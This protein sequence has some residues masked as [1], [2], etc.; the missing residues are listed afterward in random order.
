LEKRSGIWPWC[1]SWKLTAAV[2]R[3]CGLTPE[4]SGNAKLRNGM[5]LAIL[6]SLYT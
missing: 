1:S 6:P 5:T 3:V 2:K 4:I